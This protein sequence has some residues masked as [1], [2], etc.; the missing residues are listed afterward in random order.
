M[1][2]QGRKEQNQVVI[3]HKTTIYTA[4]RYFAMKFGRKIVRA[5]TGNEMR[6]L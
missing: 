2:I 3:K 1:I 5:K 4:A 6:G